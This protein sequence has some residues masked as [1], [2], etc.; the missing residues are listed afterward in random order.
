MNIL[1]KIVLTKR[2]ETAHMKKAV[3]VSE[4]QDYPEYKRKCNSL[5]AELLNNGSSG[6]IAE[7]KRK[8]P[9]KG[10]INF[11]IDLSGVVKG[12]ADGGASGLS[13]LTDSQ[14]FGGSV[15]DLMEA[16]KVN[17]TIPVLRKEFIIDPYQVVE[18]KAIGADVILLIAACLDKGV[19]E[20]L[21][22][23]AKGL[24]MEVLLEIHSEDELEK[25]NDYVD[26][27]GVNNRDL[28]TFI[29]DIKN[30]ERL[31]AYIPDNYVKISESGLEKP[32]DIIYLKK[33][34]Y[35]GF[36]IGE[37]F[38]KS[39]NPGVTCMNFINEIKLKMN[40]L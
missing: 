22:G 3:P 8:S 32:D 24:G 33:S 17:Q 36:L 21:A 1:D 37:T 30:S 9:S 20:L 14:Y 18:S 25:L 13:V 28:K 23:K 38:M 40:S 31:A 2:E 27:V 29:V 34:G 15:A 11:G 4:I 10:E 19:I 5:K 12:Y 26:F 7:F 6:I 16:R 35:R 39:E